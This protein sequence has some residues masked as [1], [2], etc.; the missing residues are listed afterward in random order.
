MAGDLKDARKRSVDNLQRLYTF[1]I[2]LAV[3]ESLRRTLLSATGTAEFVWSNK[4]LMSLSLI[5]TVI[6]FYHGANRYLDATYVTDERAA[7]RYGLMIDFFFFFIHAF[8]M[9]ILALLITNDPT[10]IATNDTYFFYGLA[11]LL[12]LDVVWVTVALFAITDRSAHAE[13]P[14]KELPYY[15]WA[16]INLVAVIIMY[17]LIRKMLW[18]WLLLLLFLRSVVDYILAHEFYYPPKE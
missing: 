2:S 16:P 4:W 12:A 14:Y 8:G 17:F 18:D 13:L 10:L 6:P 9:F 5:V 15:V 3:A 11:A 7:K 1:V